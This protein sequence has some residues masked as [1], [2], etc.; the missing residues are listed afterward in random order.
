M[1]IKVVIYVVIVVNFVLDGGGG[2]DDILRNDIRRYSIASLLTSS[3][4]S[5][6]LDGLSIYLNGADVD[7]NTPRPFKGEYLNAPWSQCFIYGELYV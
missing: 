3:S 5:T 7:D 4:S 6:T 2:D 1:L